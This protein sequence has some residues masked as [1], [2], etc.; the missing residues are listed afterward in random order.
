MHSLLRILLLVAVYTGL[1]VEVYFNKYINSYMYFLA[2]FTI[3]QLLFDSLLVYLLSLAISVVMASSGSTIL[4][5]FSTT[6]ALLGFLV[7]YVGSYTSIPSK[8]LTSLLA[9]I[10]LYI[11]S[12]ISLIPAIVLFAVLVGLSI[13]EY[14]RLSKSSVRVSPETRIVHLGEPVKYRVKITCP[15]V[16]K[17]TVFEEN[18]RTISALARDRVSLDLSLRCKLLGVNE[19]SINILV[20]DVKGFAKITHGPFTLTFKVLARI[21]H[22]LKQ[23]ER[24]IEK[25]AAY[26]STPRILKVT[27]TPVIMG[28]A[29]EERALGGAGYTGAGGLGAS[30]S[31][32]DR[33][34]IEKRGSKESFELKTA[35]SAVSRETEGSLMK[36]GF[37]K[38]IIPWRLIREVEGAV[39][40]YVAASYTGE[41]I[42]VRE[43]EPGDN[44]RVIHWKKSLRREL[45]DELY[46]KIHARE[47]ESSGGGGLTRV[48]L[49]DL[50]ATSPVELDVMLGALYGELLSELSSEKPFTQVHLFIK[51]PREGL[52]YVSGKVLDVVVALNTIIQKHTV[53]ALYNYET[54]RR[55]RSIKLG[56]STG[57]I[58]DLERYYRALGFGLVEMLE[59]KVGKRATVQLIHSNALAYKYSIIA[60]TLRDSG[61]TVL[62]SWF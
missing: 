29:G 36:S 14:L 60:Q 39:S 37:I 27:V 21:D 32:V 20:E 62:K 47:L 52:L 54:W 45:M 15:G 51:I 6:I 42:G 50:T 30:I 4:V 8:V 35:V 16:F 43:Y 24:L 7:L 59:S 38:W 48:I 34:E 3:P 58:G 40:K 10:P 31:G 44:P 46:V 18:R 26:L 55:T 11:L 57:F 25:Y 22:F 49:A 13:R 41:Y 53:R 23:A 12:P 1:I 56:E 5:F 2:L 17:Y 61:F 33:G 19:K 9:F 28:S